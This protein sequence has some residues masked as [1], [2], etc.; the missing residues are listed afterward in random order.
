MSN[1]VE[2][3]IN[4]VKHQVNADPDTSLLEIIRDDLGMTGTK[5][6]CGESECGACTVLINGTPSHACITQL[7]EIA[8]ASITTIEGL[9]KNGKLHPLQQ[10]FIDEGAMQCGY[11]VS[12]MIMTGVGLLEKNPNP[13]DAQ[14]VQFMSGNLCRCGGYPRMLA[15]IKRASQ[16]MRGSK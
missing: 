9:E 10:A 13:T 7:S 11:C 12:G 6:G 14:I 5:F 16:S 2:I 1:S 3:E 8:G 15:A 4:G